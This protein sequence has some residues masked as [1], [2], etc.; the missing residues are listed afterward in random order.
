MSNVYRKLV[1]ICVFIF[2]LVVCGEES[3]LPTEYF[4][5]LPDVHSVRV[6]P[7][8]E[9][10]ASVV[11]IDTKNAKGRSVQ[12]ADLKDGKKKFV[13]FT[14]NKKEFI[15]WIKWGNNDKLLVSL[16]FPSQ[17]WG[18]GTS[19]TRLMIV[20]IN[21]GKVRNAISKRFLNSLYYY[22]QFQD[23]IVD[24]LPDDE[25][26]FLL[27][28]NGGSDLDE[29]VYKVSLNK[30]KMSLVHKSEPNVVDWISD[31][32]G[33][34][35]IGRYFKDT[36]Y[37]IIHRFSEKD[38]W[39]VLWEFESLSEDEVWPMGFGHDGNI[40]YIDAYHEGK[41]AVFKVD[42]TDTNLKK[43]LV[44][45]NEKYDVDGYLIYSN[46]LKKAVGVEVSD[47]SGYFYWDDSYRSFM[48]KIDK[49]LSNSDNTLVSM[50]DDENMYVIYSSSSS[51]PGVY[52]LGNKKQNRLDPIAERYE[53]LPLGLMANKTRINYKARDGLDIEGYLTLPI[54]RKESDR[55]PTIIFPHGGPISYDGS[56]FDYWTQF[57]ANRG[58]AVLQMNFRGSYGYGYDFM[59]KGLSN[60]G[61]EMQDDIE[62]GTRWMIEEG[63][64]D[65][66]NICVVGASYGGYAA[67]M[68]AIKS[69]GL[70]Q[71]VVSFAGVT[72][73][74]SL[75][76]QS[77]NF[78]NHEV[79]KRMLGDN[80]GDLRSRSP[81]KNANKISVP[82]LL[83]H[84]DKD[85]RV[86]VSHSRRMRSSLEKYKKDV[87]YLE[88]KNGTHFLTRG[89]NRIATFRA[90]DDFLDKHLGLK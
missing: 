42:L 86:T 74:G 30:S 20:D 15:N 39:K 26:H 87:T 70:Y 63:Y 3:S 59:K 7:D 58:Y 45:A 4:S 90:M 53:R 34:I 49:A 43:R 48:E 18:V 77:R 6:S 72:D 79:T 52:Y 35:R 89:Q 12:V 32:Q 83:I 40:L 16:W 17:R 24:I 85:R 51:D 57:F 2:P 61:L 64:S 78:T 8:G 33:N 37:K 36:T 41:S 60:W 38:K 28:I 73:I 76:T 9:K 11:R 84:G 69:P 50:S 65:P 56:G 47:G 80:S 81:L 27:E 31:N 62:D 5:D 13:F 82:V 67:L 22:P 25:N 23:Q 1:F 46:L 66:D 75:L 21:T 44:Y 54:G 55:V 29:R 68:G 88:L 71:C 14:D 10:L 19:E